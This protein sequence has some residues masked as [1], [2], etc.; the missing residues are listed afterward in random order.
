MFAKFGPHAILFESL[1]A[2]GNLGNDQWL[3]PS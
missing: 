3:S 1:N 2:V